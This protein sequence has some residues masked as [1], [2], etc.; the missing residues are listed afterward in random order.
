MM[1]GDDGLHVGTYECMFNDADKRD[2]WRCSVTDVAGL[3]LVSAPAWFQY[4]LQT[5]DRQGDMRDCKTGRQ[6]DG[7]WLRTRKD[8]RVVID[9]GETLREDKRVH[10]RVYA[11]T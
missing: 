11:R 3:V 10:P 4:K 8:V 6:G 1:M 7:V 2:T 5:D 9:R